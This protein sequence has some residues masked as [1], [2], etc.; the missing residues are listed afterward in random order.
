MA[1]IQV[2]WVDDEIESLQAQVIFLQ[3]KG[4]SVT[5]VSNGFDAIELVKR[6]FFNINGDNTVGKT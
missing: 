3:Q 5:A 2:L 6:Q 4:Y 1:E